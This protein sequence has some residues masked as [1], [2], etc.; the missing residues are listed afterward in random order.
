M[1]NQPTPRELALALLAFGT[2]LAVL[3]YFSESNVATLLPSLLALT[4]L[5]GGLIALA[6]APPTHPRDRPLRR[7]LAMTCCVGGLGMLVGSTLDDGLATEAVP[8]CHQALSGNTGALGSSLFSWMNA[9][10]LAACLPVC[11]TLCCPWRITG[12]PHRRHRTRG[13]AVC[14]LGMLLGMYAGAYLLLPPFGSLLPPT[15][16]MHLAMLVGMVLGVAVIWPLARDHS[17]ACPCAA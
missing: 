11:S 2:Q 14:T 3:A 7:M 8:L 12:L 5:G 10:M 15:A 1:R 6:Y 13:H 9:L 4:A 16:A 17:P